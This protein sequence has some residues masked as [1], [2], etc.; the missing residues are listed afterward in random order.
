METIALRF[1]D[2]FAPPEGT[3]KAHQKII[4]ALGFVWY[5]KFGSAI[6]EKVVSLLMQ[7][8]DPRFLLIH[9]GTT[10]R[11]WVHFAEIKK[12]V[13]RKSEFPLYYQDRCGLI[14][15]WFKVTKFESAPKDVMTKF[16][17]KSSG[18]SLSE[19]SKRSMSPYFIICDRE[20]KGSDNDGRK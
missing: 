12:N 9:S 10:K 18:I 5:G 16:V 19:A 13:P 11:Y 2:G 8:E 3:I 6:S 4:D 14:K 15:T 17:V 20:N 1:S 7:M